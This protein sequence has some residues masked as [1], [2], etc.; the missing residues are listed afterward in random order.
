[1]AYLSRLIVDLRQRDVQ[2]DL[3][4]C[5]QLHDRLMRAFPAAPSP[6]NPREHFGVLYRIEQLGDLPL[7]RLLVQSEHVPNWAALPARY[8]GPAPEGH[9]NPA[10]RPLEESYQRLAEGMRLRFRLRANPTRR[11][12]DRSTVE[13]PRWRGKRIELRSDADRIAWLERKGRDHGFRP[14][15]V[16]VET[17]QP[18]AEVRIG[19]APKQYGRQGTSRLSFG[20]ALF[21]GLIDV[22]DVAQFREALD[23]GIGSGKAFGFGMLSIAEIG[24]QER[25]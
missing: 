13:D 5:H 9:S 7:A 23:R 19:D 21:D 1:M 17:E 2:R 14:V 3:A 25:A 18:I 10:V 12:S 6:D 4:D 20:V 24:R 16:R 22:T 8:L 15:Q 11:V